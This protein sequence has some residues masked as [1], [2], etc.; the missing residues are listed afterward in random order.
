M[1]LECYRGEAEILRE[2]DGGRAYTFALNHG[3]IEARLALPSPM[4]D[5]LAGET[6]ADSITLLP[7]GVAILTPA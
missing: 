6:H 1:Y 5:L 2:G 4:R 3:P 7:H